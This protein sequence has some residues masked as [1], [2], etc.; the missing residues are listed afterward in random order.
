MSKTISRRQFLT[1]MVTGVGVTTLA[2]A[3]VGAF[4]S[5]RPIDVNYQKIASIRNLNNPIMLVAYATRAGSTME[6]SQTIASELEKRN[7]TVDICP[8]DQV[9]SV[10][11]YSHIVIGSAIRMSSP[12]PEVSHFIEKHNSKL[13]NLPIA[14]FAV[15]LQNDGDDDASKIAR[16]AYLNPIRKIIGLRHE[17]YFTGVYDPGKVSIIERQMGEAV[18]TPIGDFRNWT[19]IKEWG[20]SIFPDN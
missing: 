8:I 6:I 16:L 5:H 3:G 1:Y 14:F 20:Q 11:G 4:I 9:K 2:C 17:A 19:K 12:L 18:Q 15:H 13:Q 7:F 10:E